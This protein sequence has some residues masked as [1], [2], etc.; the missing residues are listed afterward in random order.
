VVGLPTTEVAKALDS[1]A[2][3]IVRYPDQVRL[4]DDALTAQTRLGDTLCGILINRVPKEAL[5]FVLEEAVPYLEKRGIQVF[6]VIVERSG[7]EALTVA[8]LISAFEDARILTPSYDPN[9]LVERLTVGAMTADAALSRFRKQTNK[10]VITGGDRADIQLSALETSTA[11][12]V[13]TGNLQP[14]PF[15]VKQAQDLGVAVILV[16]YTTM[17][18]V[19]AL[20]AIFGKTRLG[21]VAKLQQYE[22]LL[23]EYVDLPRLY[24]CFG[25][26]K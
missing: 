25:L 22:A 26:D 14:S 20:E 11:C 5:Q 24:D 23:A 7:L 15:I 4:I 1:T 18:T 16:P 8:E 13:L 21:Q 12:L 2:L 10:A 6:G 9:A 19:E 3:A 17:E